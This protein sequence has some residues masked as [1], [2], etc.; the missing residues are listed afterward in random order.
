MLGLPGIAVSQQSRARE[1]DFRLGE[2]FDFDAAAAFTARLV[3]RARRRA[4]AARARCSTSTSRP[5]SPSGVE[6]TRL[7]KRIY[8]DALELVD[9]EDGRRRFR[10]YGDSPV[11]D[12][13][14]GTDLAAV[15]R[16]P[17]SR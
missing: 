6:V 11:H 14:P 17:R 12:D 10:I 4:A 13:E 15:A 8:R 7:G 3:E 5:A 16:R 1:M 2:R 9:E